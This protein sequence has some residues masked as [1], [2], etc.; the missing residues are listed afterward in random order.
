M[1]DLTFKMRIQSR[2]RGS[3]NDVDQV[4]VECYND[5]D[6]QALDLHDQSPGFDIFMY[7]ILSC[8]HLY[9]RLN[10]AERNLVMES[11]EG[12]ITLLTDKHRAIESMHVS[13]AGRLNSGD[14]SEETTRYIRERMSLCPVS[15]N[16]KEIADCQTAVSFEMAAS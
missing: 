1:N 10:A 9:F 15:I 12:Q 11:S 6:W 13:F 16:L 14:A 8:Q 5:G 2:Y 4:H 3:E 7:A